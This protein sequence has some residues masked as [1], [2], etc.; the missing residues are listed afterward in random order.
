MFRPDHDEFPAVNS[1]PV[2]G[3]IRSM[4]RDLS[5]QYQTRS[6]VLH[7]A[8]P[9]VSIPVGPRKAVAEVS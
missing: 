7:N 6:I 3:V 5:A 2:P 1:P 9:S 4:L 8:S